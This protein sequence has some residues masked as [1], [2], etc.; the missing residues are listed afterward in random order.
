MSQIKMS[1]TIWRREDNTQGVAQKRSEKV[2]LIAHLYPLYKSVL[3]VEVGMDMT[4]SHVF[5]QLAHGM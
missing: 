3:L 5:L 1:N 2:I 4:S